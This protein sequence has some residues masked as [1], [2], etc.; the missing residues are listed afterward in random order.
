MEY[1]KKRDHLGNIG[2]LENNINMYVKV[3]SEDVYCVKWLRMGPI[4]GCCKL[5]N[6]PWVSINGWYFLLRSVVTSF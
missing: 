4:L 5:D 1:L 6:E 3:M 2:K